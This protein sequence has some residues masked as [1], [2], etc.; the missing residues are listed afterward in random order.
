MYSA[1]RGEDNKLLAGQTIFEAS[2]NR[3]GLDCSVGPDAVGFASDA[4]G[5]FGTGL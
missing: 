1:L 2:L 4:F 3:A 5:P